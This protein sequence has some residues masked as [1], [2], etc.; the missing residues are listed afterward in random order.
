MKPLFDK[1]DKSKVMK[2][3]KELISLDPHS[4]E[5]I[6]G[7]LDHVKESK[8]KLRQCG[9]DCLKKYGY[10]IELVSM[11]LRTLDDVLCL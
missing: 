2:I 11:N 3:E 7:Y 9:K 5:G 4:F 8:L 10:L 1:V 6:E